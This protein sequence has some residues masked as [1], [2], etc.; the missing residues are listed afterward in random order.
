[1]RVLSARLA[2]QQSVWRVKIRP[3]HL[4][5]NSHGVFMQAG[6]MRNQASCPYIQDNEKSLRVDNNE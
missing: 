4:A 5:A 3:V 1:M 6:R 2:L